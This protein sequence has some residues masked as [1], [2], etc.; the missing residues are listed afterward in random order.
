M[1][2]TDQEPE[3][4]GYINHADLLAL[5][6]RN[7]DLA[8]TEA[9]F[10]RV[11]SDAYYAVF[12]ALVNTSVGVLFSIEV[13]NTPYL[14]SSVTRH[15]NHG[16]MKTVCGQFLSNKAAAIKNVHPEWADIAGDNL[17]TFQVL[18]LDFIDLLQLRHMM[19]YEP[20]FRV[21]ADDV[22]KMVATASIAIQAISQCATETSAAFTLFASRL[23]LGGRKRG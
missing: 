9:D 20:H 14:F 12:H 7:L 19:D 21:N 23:F 11:G 3:Q 5:A 10:R 8:K 16:E 6:E 15:F 22:A 18:A 4:L 13:R 17:L 2:K 1:N